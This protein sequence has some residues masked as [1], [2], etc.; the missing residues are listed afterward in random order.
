MKCFTGL[1]KDIL[2]NSDLNEFMLNS[3]DSFFT[4]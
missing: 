4:R 1:E 3:M 2:N